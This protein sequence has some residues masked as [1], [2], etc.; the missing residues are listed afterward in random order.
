MMEKKRAKS[1]VYVT[2]ETPITSSYI[3]DIDNGM[4]LS[5]LPRK[6]G[7]IRNV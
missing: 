6:T 3:L 2:Q 7:G 5:F 1:G 4:A